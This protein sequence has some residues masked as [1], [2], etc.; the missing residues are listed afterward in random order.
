MTSC[1]I[2]EPHI[3]TRTSQSY[4]LSDFFAESIVYVGYECKNTVDSLLFESL[5]GKV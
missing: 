1:P 5:G 3:L 4:T 2:A